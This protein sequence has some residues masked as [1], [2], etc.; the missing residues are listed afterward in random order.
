MKKS[1]KE[2]SEFSL[3][4]LF[5]WCELA[6]PSQYSISKYIFLNITHIIILWHYFCYL[7]CGLQFW[8][9][10]NR[11]KRKKMGKLIQK[12]TSLLISICRRVVV[13][14]LIEPILLLLDYFLAA[15]N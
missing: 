13:V 3:I 4:F 8:S 1:T 10:I 6:C 14:Y 12:D 11:R 9:S 15:K 5:N 7:S 2:N